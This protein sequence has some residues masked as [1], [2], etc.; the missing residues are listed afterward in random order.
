MLNRLA[1][2]PPHNPHRYEATDGLGIPNRTNGMRALAALDAI[3][4]YQEVCHMNEEVEVVAADLLGDL[5]HLVHS[6]GNGPKE[7]L[8]VGLSHFLHEAGP[9]QED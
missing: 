1:A 6:R 5:F 8:Q 3:S 2:N 7:F 9:V 4:R